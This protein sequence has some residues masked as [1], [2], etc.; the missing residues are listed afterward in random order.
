[1]STSLLDGDYGGDFHNEFDDFF[2][3]K[4]EMKYGDMLKIEGQE[5][6]RIADLED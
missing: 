6:H 5:H 2:S 1:M 3:A 4:S